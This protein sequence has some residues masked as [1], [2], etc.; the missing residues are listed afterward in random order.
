MMHGLDHASKGGTITF[1]K[2]KTKKVCFG[3]WQTHLWE[4]KGL[5]NGVV[6]VNMTFCKEIASLLS[7]IYVQVKAAQGKAADKPL[8]NNKPGDL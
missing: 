4:R 2:N 1:K 3:Y 7:N 8:H 6:C 5:N